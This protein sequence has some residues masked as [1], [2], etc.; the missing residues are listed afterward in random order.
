MNRRAQGQPKKRQAYK[1]PKQN[2]GAGPRIQAAFQYVQGGE[3]KR[4][5]SDQNRDPFSS[6][7]SGDMEAEQQGESLSQPPSLD[8]Y[9][10]MQEPA[11]SPGSS[12]GRNMAELTEAIFS[13]SSPDIAVPQQAHYSGDAVFLARFLNMLQQ[14]LSKACIIITTDLKKDIR[15]IGERIEQTE[16]KVDNTVKKFNQNSNMITDLQDR[17]EEAYTKIEDLENC[18]RRYNVCIRGLP[19]T[20]T[21]L[22]VGKI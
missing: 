1:Q 3:D 5:H 7:S 21:A 9:R 13:Q 11:D 12:M 6:Q 16:T 14:E 19:K 4:R 17:L 15:S 10:D 2:G 18:S 20:H 22:F 8:T